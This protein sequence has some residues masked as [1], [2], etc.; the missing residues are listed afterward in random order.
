MRSTFFYARWDDLGMR[1]Q[2][3]ILNVY[4]EGALEH[5]PLIGGHGQ[6]FIID[7]DGKRILFDTGLRGRY[8]LHNMRVLGIEPDSIDMVVLSHGHRDH[9]GGLV[10][11]LE[12]RSETLVVY[13]HPDVREKKGKGIR[14]PWKRIGFPRLGEELAAK[15]DLRPARE[16]TRISASVQLTGE[17]EERRDPEALGKRLLRWN[18]TSWELDHMRDEISLVLETAKGPVVLTGCG[19]PGLT[20][21]LRHVVSHYGRDVQAVL[22]GAHM[23]KLKKPAV[24][25]VADIIIEEFETPELYLNHCTGPN[26]IMRLREQLGLEGVKDCYVGTEVSFQL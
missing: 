16:W 24:E 5:T 19:H 10:S 20:N 11:L 4:D 15:L 18:G 6:G 22:G 7:V 23:E 13:A 9:T 26:G 3:R 25:A 1:G 12:E 14:F 21:I 8:L 17:I 2:A